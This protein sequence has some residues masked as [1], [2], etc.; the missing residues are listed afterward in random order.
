MSIDPRVIDAWLAY[1]A[2]APEAF[3]LASPGREPGGE[4]PGGR[5]LDAA[6]AAKR[7]AKR[8]G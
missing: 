8:L 7:M 4:S 6:E 5:L 1:E 3:E 2:V